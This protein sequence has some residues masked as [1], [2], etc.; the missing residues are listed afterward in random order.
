MSG[1]AGDLIAR[2]RV[3]ENEIMLVEKPFTRHVLLS[4]IR[5]A[6]Q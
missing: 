2:Y 4:K 1:Y 5:A 6:L 3:A